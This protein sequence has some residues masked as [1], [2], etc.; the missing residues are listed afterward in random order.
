[1]NTVATGIEVVGIAVF[2]VALVFWVREARKPG[3]SRRPPQPVMARLEAVPDLTPIEPARVPSPWAVD[4]LR[5]LMWID[6][7]LGERVSRELI[8]VVAGYQG[9]ASQ[10]VIREITAARHVVKG[11]LAS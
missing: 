4:M 9:D 2:L 8:R 6:R 7:Q 5:D 1:M 3:I 11:E 10:E